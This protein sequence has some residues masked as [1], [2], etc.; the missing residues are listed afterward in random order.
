MCRL[1]GLN[2]DSRNSLWLTH[3]EGQRMKNAWPCGFQKL[4]RAELHSSTAFTWLLFSFGVRAHFSCFPR[5]RHSGG[6]LHRVV[7]DAAV[8]LSVSVESGE[9]NLDLWRERETDDVNVTFLGG[10]LNHL[11]IT[12]DSSR[13]PPLAE[14]LVRPWSPKPQPSSSKHRH[15]HPISTHKIDQLRKLH[16]FNLPTVQRYYLSFFNGEFRLCDLHIA[17]LWK[18]F[19]KPRAEQL[20]GF[21]VI[22][23]ES[24]AGY[25]CQGFVEFYPTSFLPARKVERDD[26]SNDDSIDSDDSSFADEGDTIS[27]PDPSTTSAEHSPSSNRLPTRKER[28][29]Q[30]QRDRVALNPVI[31]KRVLRRES[32]ARGRRNRL[33]PPPLEIHSD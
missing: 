6:K 24:A 10:S 17:S 14:G 18:A 26:D 7:R 19:K 22:T 2:D 5:L 29:L 12:V 15:A 27:D 25:C 31:H 13:V 20:S 21:P 28:R 1:V 11:L 30:Y 16:P 32:R 9:L 8:P 4:L 23:P 3:A 33:M